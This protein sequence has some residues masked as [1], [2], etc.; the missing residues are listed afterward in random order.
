M[1]QLTTQFVVLVGIILFGMVGLVLG[2][3]ALTDWTDG[4][5]IGIVTAFGS[6]ATGLII[7]V[8]NQQQTRGAI[9]DLQQQVGA[10]QRDQTHKLDTVVRQTNGLSE[11]ERQDIAE[12]AAAAAV[13]QWSSGTL[14]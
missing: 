6:L 14:P 12:R 10:G 11:A 2:L 5:I 8:R 13:R 9:D 3:A 1:K 7:T 4:S